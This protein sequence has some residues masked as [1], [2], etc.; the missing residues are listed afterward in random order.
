MWSPDEQT[1]INKEIQ[2]LLDIGA[3]KPCKAS[4]DQFVLKIFLITKS[5]GKTRLILNLKNFN[6]FLV[7]H[8]FKMENVKTAR[9]LILP[10]SFL[11]SVDLKEAYFL[12]WVHKRHRKYLRF[13]FQNRLYE[14][15]CLPFGLCAAPYVFTKLLKPVLQTLRNQGFCSVAYLDDF[16]LMGKSHTD[17]VNNIVATVHLLN[18]LGFIINQKKS[19]LIPS[20]QCI[21]LGFLFNTE[22]MS[23]EL[24]AEKRQELFSWISK[25]G[26]LNSCSIQYFARFVGKLTAA[27]PASKYGWAHIKVWVSL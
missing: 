2:H 25:I 11:T 23:L 27:C 24:P 9:R 17:C 6:K 1:C 13:Q 12:V 4:S 5:S 26:S 10:N 22:V 7:C 3:I 15:A 8:H 19:N 18:R 21:F 14:Y 16:L 20:K